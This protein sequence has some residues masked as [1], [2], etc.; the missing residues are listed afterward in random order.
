MNHLA[1]V[2]GLYDRLLGSETEKLA[3][4]N[5]TIHKRLTFPN[6]EFADT[7]DWI[8]NHLKLPD[9]A[10]ILDAGCGVGGTLF[11]LLSTQEGGQ[12]KQPT[13]IGITL[14]Q[15]QVKV[16]KQQAARLGLASRCAFLQHSYDDPLDERFDLIISI[17]ALI[18]SPELA[19]SIKNLSQH[20]KPAGKLLIIEDMAQKGIVGTPITKIWKQ[21]W[22]IQ[23]IYSQHDYL[24]ALDTAGLKIAQNIDFTPFVRAK[25]WPSWLIQLAW[26]ITQKLPVRW[27]GAKDIF[28]GGW[29]LEHLYRHD[30]VRYRVI[31]GE[32]SSCASD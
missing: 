21:S 4:N 15:Q 1:K 31:I 22:S 12:E 23:N 17:E 26:A 20:L 9:H 10:H 24:Q 25:K 16:A 3:E 27:R 18:H 2:G 32:R 6:G 5:L 13:G 28:I 29:A 7:N 14:S 19:T 8:L 30:F 11:A